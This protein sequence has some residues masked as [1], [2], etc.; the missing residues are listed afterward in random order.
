[1][2]RFGRWAKNNVRLCPPRSAAYMTPKRNKT[3]L[4]TS[5]KERKLQRGYSTCG[6]KVS[7]QRTDKNKL[8]PHRTGVHG[9]LAGLVWSGGDDMERWEGGEGRGETA[10]GAPGRCML[11]TWRS[12][13]PHAP[14]GLYMIRV[15]TMPF[16]HVVLGDCRGNQE[17]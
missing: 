9:R 17:K 6:I 13:H 1:M 10:S 8:S 4:G 15:A 7:Q 14:G 16:C 5:K 2:A 11:R 3:T 12:R